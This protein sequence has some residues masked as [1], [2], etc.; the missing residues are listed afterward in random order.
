MFDSI[1]DG[2]FHKRTAEKRKTANSKTETVKDPGN[3]QANTIRKI[4]P[5]IVSMGMCS[6]DFVIWFNDS[7]NWPRAG[8]HDK[9]TVSSGISNTLQ[10]GGPVNTTKVTDCCSSANL[11]FNQIHFILSQT[12]VNHSLCKIRKGQKLHFWIEFHIW[13]F[14][15]AI[16]YACK[17]SNL[18]YQV[19]IMLK[20]RIHLRS[21]RFICVCIHNS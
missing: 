2:N 14:Q 5:W 17:W 11:P 7:V 13:S 6:P 8:N 19:F 20:A 9:R 16:L 10:N 3:N 4:S 1:H 12:L 18:P 15:M 21:N